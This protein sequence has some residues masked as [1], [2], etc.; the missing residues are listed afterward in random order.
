MLG[1]VDFEFCHSTTCL[2]LLGQMEVWQNWLV[3]LGKRM[4]HPNQSQPHPGPRPPG[5]PCND[6]LAPSQPTLSQVFQQCAYYV[7][8]NLP[9]ANSTVICL[10]GYRNLQHRT[11][12]SSLA[13]RL[14]ERVREGH[15]GVADELELRLELRVGGGEALP[16]RAPPRVVLVVG[17]RQAARVA[18]LEVVLPELWN[19]IQ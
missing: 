19:G 6:V 17:R 4:K 7:S 16:A 3:Q 18:A 14:P 8:A 13:C 15:D 1:W 10:C 5:S 11:F 12:S 2:V 9:L